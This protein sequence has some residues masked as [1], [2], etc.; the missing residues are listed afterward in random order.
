MLKI[1]TFF[2]SYKLPLMIGAALL[3]AGFIYYKGWSSSIQKNAMAVLEK[4]LEYVDIERQ[5]NE[6]RDRVNSSGDVYRILRSGS[7]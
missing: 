1:L 4:S 2:T 5:Q 7:Y 3:V 6:E